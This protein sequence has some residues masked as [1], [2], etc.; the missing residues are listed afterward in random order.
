MQNERMETCQHHIHKEL[1]RQIRT[2]CWSRLFKLEFHARTN[3]L[4]MQKLKIDFQVFL[5]PNITLMNLVTEG[6]KP[7]ARTGCI[8]R[9][10]GKRFTKAFLNYQQNTSSDISEGKIEVR[11]LKRAAPGDEVHIICLW[12]CFQRRPHHEC[13]I[14]LEIQRIKVA[15]SGEEEQNA[16][17]LTRGRGGSGG[18]EEEGKG[19]R[20][21]EKRGEA[22]EGRGR[23][24][25]RS[26][27]SS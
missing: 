23:V 25:G 1:Q 24:S 5:R 9:Q 20:S 7:N 6:L 12:K 21:R 16:P 26:S 2:S 18:E 13:V 4:L 11:R 10:A 27:R 15:S 22:G 19:V 3:V 14:W 8:Q 17:C